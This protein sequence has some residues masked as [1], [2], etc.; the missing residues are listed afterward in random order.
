MPDS[1]LTLYHNRRRRR[2]R[3]SRAGLG[4]ADATIAVGSGTASPVTVP[5]GQATGSVLMTYETLGGVPTGAI[6]DTGVASLTAN[7]TSF[8]LQVG[9]IAVGGAHEMLDSGF[10]TTVVAFDP[11]N[12]RAQVYVNGRIVIDA[13]GAFAAWADASTWTYVNGLSNL[14]QVRD[15]EVF[16][17]QVPAIF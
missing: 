13:T 8:L 1:Q 5:Q 2:L 6:M 7:S 12:N 16:I 14:G 10:Y 4:L 11:V 9:A 15:L 17:A 3:Y